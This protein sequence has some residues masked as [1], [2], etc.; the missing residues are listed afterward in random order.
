MGPGAE[1]KAWGGLTNHLHEMYRGKFNTWHSRHP[2]VHLNPG[3]QVRAVLSNTKMAPRHPTACATGRGEHPTHHREKCCLGG[4][5]ETNALPNTP[6][7]VAGFQSDRPRGH[8]EERPSSISQRHTDGA[9]RRIQRPLTESESA[10]MK[11]MPIVPIP[12]SSIHRSPSV[13]LLR[14]STEQGTD[15]RHKQMAPRS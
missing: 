11:P 5:C 14:P 15:F 4:P 9:I 6:D 8:P 10:R 1:C 2:H 3:Q 12:I 7:P 13:C